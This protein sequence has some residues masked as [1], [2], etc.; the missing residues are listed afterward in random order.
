MF[1]RNTQDSAAQVP[2]SREQH[3]QQFA[4]QPKSIAQ[5]E[6]VVALSVIHQFF[7]SFLFDDLFNKFNFIF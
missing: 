7:S 5:N 4:Q 6:S 2:P 1:H 3:S